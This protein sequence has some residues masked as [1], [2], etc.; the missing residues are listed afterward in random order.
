MRYTA[1]VGDTVVDER[2]ATTPLVY[3][4]GAFFVPGMDDAIVGRCVQ[5]DIRLTWSRAPSID[6]GARD[7]ALPAGPLVIELNLERCAPSRTSAQ[8]MRA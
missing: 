2:Y 5:S 6:W 1:K 7:G 3:Q 4:L 8:Q